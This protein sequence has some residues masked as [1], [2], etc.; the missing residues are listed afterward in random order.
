MIS[1]H[2]REPG[3]IIIRIQ[4]AVP[5]IVLFVAEH[6]VQMDVLHALEKIAFDVGIGLFQIG[7]QMFG[8]QPLGI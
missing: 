1:G 7:D 3:L 8:F 2:I 5:D 4:K 6:S